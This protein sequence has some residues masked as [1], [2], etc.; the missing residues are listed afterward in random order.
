MQ[1]NV[2]TGGG[3]DLCGLLVKQTDEGNLSWNSGS[4]EQQQ[5]APTIVSV[6]THLSHCGGHEERKDEVSQQRR[7]DNGGVDSLK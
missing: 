2:T 5:A 7:K 3:G 6:V 4:A 1:Q